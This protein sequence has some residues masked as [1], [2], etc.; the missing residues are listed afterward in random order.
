MIIRIFACITLAIGALSAINHAMGSA[1]ISIAFDL[2]WLALGFGLF[3]IDN[4]ART[5]T[6]FLSIFTS[7]ALPIVCIAIIVPSIKSG[8]SSFDD[9]MPVIQRFSFILVYS[10][11]AIIL[12]TRP[13]IRERFNVTR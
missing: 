4:W 2:V 8:R 10:L 3:R 5:A 9:L 1:R 13:T 7:I 12:M 6:L 11:T